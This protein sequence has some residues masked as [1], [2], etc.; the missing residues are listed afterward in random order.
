M[1]KRILLVVC[2]VA[3]AAMA[4]PVARAQETPAATAGATVVE[5]KLGTAVE[6]REV[7]GEAATFA[8][9]A[10]VVL[11]LKITGDAGGKITVTWSNGGTTKATELEV[12]GS[13]WRTWAEKTVRQSGEWTVT[14]S[15]ADG[16]ELKK[17]AFNVE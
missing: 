2:L 17:L 1:T 6:N 16:K 13:P 12:K 5:A 14:V 4:A 11:W 15:S 9:N 8:K 10:K 3:I 7:T